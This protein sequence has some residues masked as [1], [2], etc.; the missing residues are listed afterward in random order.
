VHAAVAIEDPGKDLRPAEVDTDD[1][2]GAHVRWV[3]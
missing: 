3:T 2:L 1:S